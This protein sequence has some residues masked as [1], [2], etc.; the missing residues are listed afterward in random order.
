MSGQ[1][2]RPQQT[3][4]PSAPVPA[5]QS[6]AGK[7]AWWCVLGAAVTFLFVNLLID[8]SVESGGLVSVIRVLLIVACAAFSLGALASAAQAITRG[9]RGLMVWVAGAIGLAATVLV[10]LGLAGAIPGVFG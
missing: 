3:P 2:D 1:P 10:A 5:P 4:T 7:R 8:G 6:E 9:D